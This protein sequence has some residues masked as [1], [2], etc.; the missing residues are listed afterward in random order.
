[1]DAL[2]VCMFEAV[3][4][5]PV[6][7][8]TLSRMAATASN[9]GFDGIVTRK[10]V[11]DH[12]DITLKKISEAFE[13]TVFSGMEIKSE[14]TSSLSGHINGNRFKTPVLC[15]HGGDP[16][17][18]L[19]ASK[20]KSLDVLC[21]PMDS[22]GDLN[23]VIVKEAMRNNVCIEINF[24]DILRGSGKNRIRS[25]GK[26]RKQWDLISNYG[27]P[28]VVS[29]DPTSHLEMRSPTDLISIGELIGMS[30]ADV[31]QGLSKWG[32]I[33]AHNLEILRNERVSP[34]VTR[35]R[36]GGEK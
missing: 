9:Y 10:F 1:M 21:H 15:V 16:S 17:V 3:H 18:N 19:F 14:K 23:Q 22:G 6:G 2:S 24:R 33:A 20:Q 13:I 25:L 8:S 4:I 11:G 28:F 5:F 35:G 29:A 36:Y 31:K 7:K 34:G 32:E 12:S 30:A 26:T 27:A